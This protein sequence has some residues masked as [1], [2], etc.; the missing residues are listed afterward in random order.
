MVTTFDRVKRGDLSLGDAGTTK[1]IQALLE[2]AGPGEY[3]SR[4]RPATHRRTR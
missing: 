4:S 1:E 3:P 2:D